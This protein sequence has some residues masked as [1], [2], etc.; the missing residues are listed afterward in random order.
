MILAG[1]KKVA[2]IDKKVGSFS[3]DNAQ[4]EVGSFTNSRGDCG[5]GINLVFPS[6]APGPF[7]PRGIYSYIFGPKEAS[8]FTSFLDQVLAEK[9]PASFKFSR[10]ASGRWFSAGSCTWSI[11]KF[12][13]EWHGGGGYK[14]SIDNSLSYTITKSATQELREC[15]IE[16]F[17]VAA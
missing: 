1:R 11:T 5:K 17:G 10:D 4:L 7:G 16:F 13:V 2:R 12:I 3:L 14:G 6:I 9:L 8:Q 15:V